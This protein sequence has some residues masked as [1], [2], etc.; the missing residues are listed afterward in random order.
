MTYKLVVSDLDGT[1]LT[2]EHRVGEYT[3]RI[4]HGLSERGIELAIAS[5]RHFQDVRA[6]AKLFGAEV[7]TISSN[8]AAVYSGSGEV[9]EMTAI[10]G[11]CLDFLL[12]DPAFS[13]AHTNVF[14]AHEWLVS[15]AE[16]RLLVYHSETGFAYRVTDLR[17]L[18]GE[19]VLKV[20]FYGA[21]PELCALE[22][23]IVERCGRRV[24]TTFPLPSPRG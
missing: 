5:G 14:C 7:Y 18:D 15:Q 8:G 6:L 10:E 17:R 20:F 11:D 4:L 9:M 13:S 23:Y 16:P 24:T 12:S 21:N 19:P 22:D 3:R 1:L 2:S